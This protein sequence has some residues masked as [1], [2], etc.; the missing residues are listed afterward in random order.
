MLSISFLLFF[1][2]SCT[3]ILV[4]PDREFFFAL[5]CLPFNNCIACY[6]L[7][8]SKKFHIIACVIS[9]ACRKILRIPTSFFPFMRIKR[10]K[11]RERKR[12][13]WSLNKVEILLEISKNVGRISSHF[14][15]SHIV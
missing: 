9:C 8:Q 14:Y 2:L 7:L 10:R 5:T 4:L 13:N 6:S 15:M 1:S 3:H 12:E 11:K